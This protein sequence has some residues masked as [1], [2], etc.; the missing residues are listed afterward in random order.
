MNA[1]NATDPRDEW[2]DIPTA[3]RRSFRTEWLFGFWIS[4]LFGQVDYWY[5][6]IC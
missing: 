4:R 5:T 6:F 1:L 2:R 3:A